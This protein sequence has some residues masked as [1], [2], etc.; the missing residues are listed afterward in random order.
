[1]HVPSLK[2]NLVSFAML[3]DKGYDVVF[4]N[5]KSFLQHKTMGQ[6]KKI[7]I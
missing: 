2:K 4:N 3:E 1:M 7:G 5:G 6:I